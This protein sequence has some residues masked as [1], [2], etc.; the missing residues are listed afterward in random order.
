MAETRYKMTYYQIISRWC[1]KACDRKKT[2]SARVGFSVHK[3]YTQFGRI[4]HARLI[5]DS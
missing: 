3:P 4:T 2:A 1:G 5:A